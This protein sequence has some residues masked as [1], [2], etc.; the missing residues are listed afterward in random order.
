MHYYDL[1]TFLIFYLFNRHVII[2]ISLPKIPLLSS[3]TWHFFMIPLHE[4]SLWCLYQTFHYHLFIRR[5]IIIILLPDI[6]LIWSLY[7][8]FN[9]DLFTRYFI[10]IISFQS[11][12]FVR[13]CLPKFLVSFVPVSDFQYWF[14][15]FSPGWYVLCSNHYVGLHDNIYYF[16]LLFLNIRGYIFKELNLAYVTMLNYRWNSLKL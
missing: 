5:F 13:Y 2:M 9:Y 15:I 4:I 1:F 14:L 3:F 16:Y 6:S 7:Q 8:T 11:A 12:S 10:I